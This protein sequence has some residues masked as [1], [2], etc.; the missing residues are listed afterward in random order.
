MAEHHPLTSKKKTLPYIIALFLLAF[1]LFAQIRDIH[2]IAEY[3]EH[4]DPEALLLFDIDNTI[5]EPTQLLGSDQ[6]FTYRQAYYRERG[7]TP[8]MALENAL[9]EWMSIQNL[10]RVRLVEAETADL[11][12]DLQSQGYALMGLTTRGLGLALRTIE[13]LQTLAVNL[14]KT[15]PFTEERFFTTERGI[16]FRNGILFTAGTHKGTAFLRLF[17][18]QLPKKVIFI[19]DK[20]SDLAQVEEICEQMGIPFLGL[21]YGFLDEKVKNFSEELAAV[22]WEHFGTLLSDEAARQKVKRKNML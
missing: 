20:K 5:M 10:T 12:R 17:E 21:R 3:K 4:V 15:A 13:Q 16:L 2:T 14:S 18:G 1:P 8:T 11:I 22:Q 7:Y 19:N 6:W 9:A